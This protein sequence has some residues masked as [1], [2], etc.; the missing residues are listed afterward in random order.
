MKN[1][2]LKKVLTTHGLATFRFCAANVRLFF[3]YTT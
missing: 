2:S 1:T 3:E